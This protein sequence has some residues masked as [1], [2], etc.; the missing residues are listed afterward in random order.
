VIG[1]RRPQA[2]VRRLHG[3]C[4]AVDSVD[5]LRAA[6]AR[7]DGLGVSHGEV[8]ELADFGLAILSLQDPDDIN[9]E[10]VAELPTTDE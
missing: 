9:L 4:L 5:D 8:T 3:W 6:T 1:A 2:N 7:L 10:L